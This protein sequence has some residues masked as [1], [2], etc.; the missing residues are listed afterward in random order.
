M[1]LEIV[2]ILPWTVFTQCVLCASHSAK[3]FYCDLI[4][5]S[6]WFYEVG[7]I[8][9]FQLQRRKS[10]HREVALVKCGTRI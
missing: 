9:I 2:E 4:S 3:L 8:V 1:T 7:T 10:S 6:H 5:F